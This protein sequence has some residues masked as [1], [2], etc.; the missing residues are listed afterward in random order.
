MVTRSTPWF[1][2]MSLEFR[3]TNKQIRMIAFIYLL[4]ACI[5][6]G[7][8]KLFDIKRFLYCISKSKLPHCNIGYVFG[9]IFLKTAENVGLQIF[10]SYSRI[11]LGMQ[12]DHF[13]EQRTSGLKFSRFFLNIFAYLNCLY[14]EN[15][16]FYEKSL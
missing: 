8:S 1:L 10:H 5:S 11:F 6:C 15:K 4:F 12:R 14:F 3:V 13:Q 9:S 7:I 2:Y 16:T